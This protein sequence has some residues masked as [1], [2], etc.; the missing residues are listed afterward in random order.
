MMMM[1]II[2][3]IIWIDFPPFTNPGG[4]IN[5][6]G[7]RSHAEI[8]SADFSPAEKCRFI[9]LINGG[10]VIYRGGLF[11]RSYSA[12]PRLYV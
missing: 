1:I 12:A 3:N 5:G 2:I 4:V 10:V 8:D 11:C 6:G 9:G 7:I